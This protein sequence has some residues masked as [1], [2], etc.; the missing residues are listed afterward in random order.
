MLESTDDG[1]E[2]SALPADALAK[3][4]GDHRLRAA[5]RNRELQRV[6]TES[7]A[8][9]YDQR[10]AVLNRH[11]AQNSDF[12]TFVTDV[13]SVVGFSSASKS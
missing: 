10:S 11:L 2:L 8:A 12:S 3:L 5:L 7:D 6:I 13:L 1:E 9:P 4:A